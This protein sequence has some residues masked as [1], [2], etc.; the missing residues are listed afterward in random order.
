MLGASSG[1]TCRLALVMC[2][3]AASVSAVLGQAPL[4]A[5]EP[6]PAPLPPSQ[7]GKARA[8]PRRPAPGA[9]PGPGSHHGNLL[10]GYGEPAPTY[11]PRTIESLSFGV[12]VECYLLDRQLK[13]DMASVSLGKG[14][15]CG[16]PTGEYFYALDPSPRTAP[17]IT[18][19]SRRN[20]PFTCS[21]SIPL[22]I[23]RTSRTFPACGGSCK[24]PWPS[25][26]PRDRLASTT[27][28]S[29]PAV[30]RWTSKRSA[31]TAPPSASAPATPRSVGS[32]TRACK[33]C[34]ASPTRGNRRPAAV[35]WTGAVLRRAAPQ[36]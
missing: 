28:N 2:L 21:P 29:T 22:S 25:A 26:C 18:P 20:G 16:D 35:Q 11:G 27:P 14:G 15:A 32:S 24:S 31:S 19:M 6:L 34:S 12:I 17:C 5:P 9:Y 1:R 3:A 8:G 4:P 7:P 33:R 10:P 30:W 36:N 13:A 23:S